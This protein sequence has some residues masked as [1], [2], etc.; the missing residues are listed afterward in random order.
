M[1]LVR[2]YTPVANLV[3]DHVFATGFDGALKPYDGLVDP[4]VVPCW[5]GLRPLTTDRSL[6]DALVALIH[7]FAD[8]PRSDHASVMA[9]S[10]TWRWTFLQCGQVNVR[11]SWPVS[12]GSIAASFMG[13]PQAVHSGPWF[14]MSSM[15]CPPQFGALG[16]P[17]SQ[18]AASDL[19]GSD[20]MTLV[21][22]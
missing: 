9:L 14:C 16:C 22:T 6:G 11:R 12:L 15:C 1:C 21:S 8:S 2:N 13:E 17:E 7:Y 4:M 20:A 5:I 19:K 18:P 3:S 10:M